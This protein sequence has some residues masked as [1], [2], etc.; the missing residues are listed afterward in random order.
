MTFGGAG[1]K[2]EATKR[3]PHRSGLGPTE[4]GWIKMSFLAEMQGGH[5]PNGPQER[6]SHHH[7]AMLPISQ[8]PDLLENAMPSL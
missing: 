4:L 7:L 5:A 2:G 8:P 6:D 3:T 1:A